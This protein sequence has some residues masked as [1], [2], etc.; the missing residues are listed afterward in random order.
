M[1]VAPWRKVTVDP[2]E[3]LTANA[4]AADVVLDQAQLEALPTLRVPT[5]T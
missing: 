3:E 1:K 2:V 5:N 4:S